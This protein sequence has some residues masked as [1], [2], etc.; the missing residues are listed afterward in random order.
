[1]AQLDYKIVS[2]SHEGRHV[3]ANVRVYRGAIT[4][5]D[6]MNQQTLVLEPVTRY[7]RIAVVRER[8]FEYDVPR[9]MTRQEFVTKVRGYLNKKLGDFASANGHTVI[10]DQQDVSDYEQGINETEQ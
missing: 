6:E 2:Y 3:T 7:R 1:M 5:E 8:T 10:T 4:T 9:D